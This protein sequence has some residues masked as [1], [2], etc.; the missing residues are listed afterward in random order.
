MMS[1]KSYLER[2]DK[3]LGKRGLEK[4]PVT[5]GQDMPQATGLEKLVAFFRS[6]TG[7]REKK[8]KTGYH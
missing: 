2:G 3:I 6:F 8:K 7:R 1:E 5:R 4:S